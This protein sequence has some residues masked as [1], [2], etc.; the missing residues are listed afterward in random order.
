M[1]QRRAQPQ[2]AK[3][4]KNASISA[5]TTD[6]FDFL[7]SQ[8]STGSDDQAFQLAVAQQ[9]MASKE[10]KRQ[11][12]EK[13]FL[14]AARHKLTGEISSTS[15]ET[16]KTVTGAEELYAKFIL[17]YAEAEDSIRAI[18][19]EITTEEKKLSQIAK[20]QSTA[21]QQMRKENESPMYTG[22]GRMKEACREMREIIK[23]LSD[24]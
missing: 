18:W 12:K 24:G 21:R 17:D 1:A 5:P 3:L 6:D 13:K 16:Q 14:V 9:M 22:M 23:E 2:T 8:Q 19:T 20:R 4:R 7:A 10:K 15:E 11:E